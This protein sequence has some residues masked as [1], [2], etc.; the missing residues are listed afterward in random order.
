MKTIVFDSRLGMVYMTRI[1]REMY[2]ASD[3]RD[4]QIMKLEMCI[5]RV[6]R[7]Y[8]APLSESPDVEHVA[9]LGYN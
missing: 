7:H 2:Q 5:K 4:Y 8:R 1:Y 9:V 6:M 3:A